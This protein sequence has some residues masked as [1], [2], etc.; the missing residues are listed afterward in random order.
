MVDIKS[1]EGLLK[2][3]KIIFFSIH[4]LTL[5]FGIFSKYT[6]ARRIVSPC[7]IFLSII[8]SVISIAEFIVEKDVLMIFFGMVAVIGFS[9]LLTKLSSICFNEDEI[10]SLFKWIE[11][12]YLN[13]SEPILAK[14]KEKS[15]TKVL[16]LLKAFLKFYISSLILGL[17]CANL[18]Y[19]IHDIRL[20]KIPYLPKTSNMNLQTGFYCSCILLYGA[21]VMCFGCMGIMFIG[22]LKFFNECIA[23]MEDDSLNDDT[24]DGF[25]LLLH[26]MHCKIYMKFRIYENIFSFSVFF[27]ITLN[28]GIIIMVLVLIRLYPSNAICYIFFV[29]VTSQ[30]V[31]YCLFG[32]FFFSETDNIP[33]NL[34]LT[35]WYDMNRK[36]KR[37]LLLMLMM[38]SR[39]FG[40]K[41]AGMYDIN[42][43]LFVKIMKLTFTYCAILYTFL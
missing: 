29:T 30:L 17:C 32:D 14:V 3:T 10:E 37:V 16:F 25:I 6:F 1:K 2:I 36:D 9:N 12:F 26:K 42:I 7:L 28:S 34:Y 40:L 27:E 38:S 24:A 23:L 21:P 13:D 41:A 33:I 35:K 11:D 20:L 43:V 31:I 15:L 5:N 19:N 39:P 8:A 4:L 18:L 22:I